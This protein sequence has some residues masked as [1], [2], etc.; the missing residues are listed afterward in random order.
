MMA[1][2]ISVERGMVISFVIGKKGKSISEKAEPL[3]LAK[4]YDVDYYI[5]IYHH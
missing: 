4:D 3:E 5:N 1:A 2:G